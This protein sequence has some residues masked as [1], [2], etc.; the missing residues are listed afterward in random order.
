VLEIALVTCRSL[1]DLDEDD[2]LLIEPL[3]ALGCRVTAA[4]WDDPKVD[5]DRFAVSVIRSTWDYTKSRNAFVTR[6]QSV[7]RLLNAAEVVAW[8]TDKRYLRHLAAAGVPVVPTAWIS[9]TASL[10]LPRL[11][12]MSSSHP[13]VPGH[14]TRR[15]TI[16]AIP[17]RAPGRQAMRSV[18]LQAARQ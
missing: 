7:P 16:S 15:A 9:D 2:R 10:D 3:D 6:A 13:S 4:S 14:L 17:N 18:Y 8:N 5:W 11:E 12:N 1:P